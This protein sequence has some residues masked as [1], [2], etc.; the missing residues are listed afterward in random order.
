TEVTNESIAIV[1]PNR[2]ID[3]TANLWYAIV[4]TLFVALIVT[5]IV[6]R[7]TE[8]ALGPYRPEEAGDVAHDESDVP[9]GEPRGL[10]F[11]ALGAL[12]A[13]VVVVLLA[14][15]PDAPLRNPETGDLFND[16]PLMDGLI[17]IITMVFL[18]AG[19]CFGIGARTI[20]SA[21]DVIN[22]IVKTF[23]GLASLIFLLLLISQF[24]AF[25]NFSNMP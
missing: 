3:L 23:A 1:D 5:L 19:I 11:A 24:I 12:A 18:V 17:F 25:F 15:F 6:Q 8:P 10:R 7:V 22:A 16:S 20:S 9:E 2:S 4:S 14:A 21:V 13:I